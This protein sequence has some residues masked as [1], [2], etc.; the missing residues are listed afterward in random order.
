MFGECIALCA[1]PY[2]LGG[3]KQRASKLPRGIAFM[4]EQVKRDALRRAR[5]DAW[6]SLEPIDQTINAWA[7]FHQKPRSLPN[8]NQKIRVAS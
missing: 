5:P 8:T 2:M 6:K 7:E 1:V 4:L 3:F